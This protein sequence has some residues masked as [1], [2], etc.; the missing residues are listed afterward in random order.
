MRRQQRTEW[1]KSRHA[2]ACSTC[3]Y[4]NRIPIS[5]CPFPGSRLMCREHHHPLLFIATLALTSRLCALLLLQIPLKAFD[6]S[7]ELVQ[8]SGSI[9]LRWDGLHFLAIA[10]KGYDYEQQLAFQ[11][12]WPGLIRVLGEAIAWAQGHELGVDDVLTGAVGLSIASFVGA[13]VMLHKWASTHS[14]PMMR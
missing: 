4:V 2:R 10:K 3:R 9:T 11:P 8:T 12:G 6:S 13:A 7:H 1:Q 14:R 5:S